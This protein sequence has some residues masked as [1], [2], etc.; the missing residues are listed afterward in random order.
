MSTLRLTPLLLLPLLACSVEKVEPRPTTS[1]A[2]A[3]AEI[4]A[5]WTQYTAAQKAADTTAWKAMVTEDA[6]FVFTGAETLRGRDRAT[7][8]LSRWLSQNQIVV[9]HVSSE[10][11]TVTGNRAFQLARVHQ[12]N[13][14][15][16]G[17]PTEEFSR[18]AAYFLKDGEGRWRLDRGV[19]IIDS[20]VTR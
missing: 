13:R 15:A 9:V 6:V 14:A 18:I 11:V 16:G 4:A 2:T 1:S 17:S 5:F 20:T 8:L 12:V 7:A 19:F 3:S 10:E